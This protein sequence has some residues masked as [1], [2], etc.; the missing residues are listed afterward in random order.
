MANGKNG[1]RKTGQALL[2]LY[3]AALLYFILKQVY[4]AL[5]VGGFPDQTAQVS[6]L[7]EMCRQPRLV[8]DFAALPMYPVL[9][10]ENLVWTMRASATAVNYLGHP[11]LYYLLLSLT[12]PVRFLEDGTVAVDMLK[13][14]LANTVLTS[15]AALLAFRLGYRALKGRSPF[16]HLLFAF[17]V[18]TLPELGYVGVSVNNDNLA[19]FAFALFFTGVMRYN[20]DK[21]DLPTYLLIGLGFML[22]ALSKLTAALIMLIMLVTILVMSVIRTK[23]LKLIL[24][25]YFLMTLPCYL[26]FLAYEIAVHRRYGSWQP[27][28]AQIA[29]EY[30]LTTS[31][32]VAP[33]NRVPMTFLQFVRSFLGGI[34]HTWSSF[35]GHNQPVNEIMDNR[36]FGLVYWIPVAAAMLAA[37]LQ[38]IRRKA[39]RY[40]IPAV[41]A[42]LGTLAYHLY[43]NWSGFLKNGYAGGSQAR[44]YLFLIIPFAL[45]FT[46]SIP[47]PKTQKAKVLTAAF[48]LLLTALWLL[49]DAPRLLLTCG[50][51]P[52][53]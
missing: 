20:E 38:L 32:Y 35:Y 15:A 9:T 1:A 27:G 50:L 51:S 26:L 47:E 19:F 52:S 13:L 11:P 42:F 30:Y 23:S 12:A 3:G 53:F 16:L 6:Y 21:L 10:Q 25:K 17:A 43:S 4:F 33:E 14:Y 28:L 37:L 24:N 45:A 39:D 8:P 31:F 36:L 41:L 48:A 18:V 22:G 2:F 7:I 29:P 49:G 40:T 46:Q 34:G 5:A 44:Y